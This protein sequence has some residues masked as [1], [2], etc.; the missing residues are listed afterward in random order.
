MGAVDGYEVVHLKRL[1]L[2]TNCDIESVPNG[3]AT[4]SPV[5][6]SAQ[7]HV[8]ILI[9]NDPARRSDRVGL[10]KKI[11]GNSPFA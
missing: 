8:V 9:L 11:T 5:V 6:K 10:N 7:R 1:D 2:R 4:V 3:R